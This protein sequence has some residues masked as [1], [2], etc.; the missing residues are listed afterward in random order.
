ME[1][2]K[3]NGYIYVYRQEYIQAG[4]YKIGKTVNN[5][6]TYKITNVKETSTIHPYTFPIIFHMLKH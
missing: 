4:I 3:D 2:K 1:N 6:S 5:K